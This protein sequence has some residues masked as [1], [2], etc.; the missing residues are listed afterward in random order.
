MSNLQVLILIDPRPHSLG[1][2]FKQF[3]E[4]I[5]QRTDAFKRLVHIH[6]AGNFTGLIKAMLDSRLSHTNVAPNEHKAGSKVVV[7][8]LL[9]AEIS[10]VSINV[11]KAMNVVLKTARK[12]V[13]LFDALQHM[14]KAGNSIISSVVCP[15][16]VSIAQTL[17]FD[18][19][20]HLLLIGYPNGRHNR[21][22]RTYR[23]H[24]RR[25]IQFRPSHVYT[26]QP[27]KC[28]H[29][30]RRYGYPCQDQQRPHLDRIFAPFL[31]NHH[32]TPSHYIPT[33]LPLAASL[34]HGGAA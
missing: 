25:P 7:N 33:R 6:V 13:P 4:V 20:L 1:M 21:S 18:R 34:V 24:P 29:S 19:C 8:H 31:R 12:D 16:E 32:R 5:R 22:N 26:K 30:Q 14:N 10:K 15:E 3:F 17:T 28:E 23:L 9:E 2:G 11:F 27:D